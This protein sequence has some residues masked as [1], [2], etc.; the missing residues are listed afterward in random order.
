MTWYQIS[1]FAS[2]HN[3]QVAREMMNQIYIRHK[4]NKERYSVI[5]LCPSVHTIVCVGTDKSRNGTEWNE[6][7]R[8]L[9]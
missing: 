9:T 8:T 2:P 6:E 5:Y 3:K 1:R 4:D 7:G